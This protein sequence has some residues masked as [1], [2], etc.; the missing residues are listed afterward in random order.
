VEVTTKELRI[1]PGK[2]LEQVVNGD[3]ITV[4][5]RGKA[6][7]KIIPFKNKDQIADTD[8]CS[9]FGLWKDHDGNE[10]VEEYVRNVR[11]GRRF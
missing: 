2:I 6:L 5:F 1:Q 7:A 10:T 11:K 9:I 8:E 3:E 4:T